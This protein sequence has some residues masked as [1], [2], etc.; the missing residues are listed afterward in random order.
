MIIGA[1]I[2]GLTL[3][4]SLHQAG[5]PCRVLEGAPEIKPLGAGINLLPHG[6]R[7]LTDL[8]M[9]GALAARSVATREHRFYT[10]HGQLIHSEARGIAAGYQWPQF[11]IHRGE[12]QLALL[13][14]VRERLGEDSVLLD[15]RCVSVDQ[16]ESGVQLRFV[17]SAGSPKPSLS[18]EIAVGCDGIHSFVR[19]KLVPDEGAPRYSG[20][21]MWRGVTVA[22]PFLNGATMV[23]IGWY[24]SGCMVIYPI[25]DNVDGRGDQLVNWVAQLETPRHDERSWSRRG[26]LADFLPQFESFV[27]DWL[28]VPALI[29]GTENV[30]EYPMIDQDPLASWTDGRIT[31]LGDAAHPMYP[32]GS[33]GAGQAVLDAGCLAQCLKD[34]PDKRDALA[35]YEKIRLEATTKLVLLNRRNPPDAIL[36]EVY[37]RTGDKP[38]ER[39]EDVIAAHEIQAIASTYKATAG[40]DRAALAVERR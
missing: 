28:D 14:A 9:A 20:I 22:P 19:K 32:R 16:D 36:R 37:E 13:N 34:L 15:H 3:A 6:V 33:N 39:L 40:F 27:F 26:E 5:I 35:A 7:H 2:G 8:G 23:H 11:S 1:G 17:D 25:Q 21:N 18:G 31:L 12:L 29:R 4:L 30:F 10:R 24:A 38:F